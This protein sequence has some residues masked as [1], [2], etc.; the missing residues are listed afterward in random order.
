MNLSNCRN[1]FGKKLNFLFSLGELSFTGKFPKTNKENIP[2]KEISLV[3]CQKCHLVQLNK[4][5]NLNYLYNTDYG[6]RSGINHT[7]R[8][9]LKKVVENLIKI[10]EPKNNDYVLDIASNDGTLLNFYNKKLTTIGVDP[11][12]K[13]F[14]KFYR[15]IN[16]RI[17]GFFSKK[18]LEKILCNNKKIKIISALS[19][20][21]D[22]KK[23]ND[24]LKDI[25]CI[26]DEKVGVFYL[27]FC[28]LGSIIK[29]NLFDTI[30]HEHLE[31]YSIE[32]IIDMA[33]KNQLRVFDIVQNNI[34][35]GSTGF[36]IC[37]KNALY[38]NN[39]TNINKILK[40]EIKLNLKKLKTYKNLFNNILKI[41]KKLTTML[42][43][44]T[45]KGKIIHGY[46]ASTKGNVLIQFFDLNKN[47]IRF[48]S[49]RNPEKKN[50][51]TPGSKIK[52]I[53]EKLSRRLKPD[54]YLVLPWHFKKEILLREK[55]MLKFGTRFIFP[56]PKIK[57][58]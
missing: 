16:Y 54:Y 21:Y 19:V 22:L 38:K 29:K 36:Y 17:N 44:L 53:S 23:P 25:S 8:N 18:V 6:Y 14:S 50:C 3:K 40:T 24:F 20:F 47:Q 35:G 10:V 45:Q 42:E 30:C 5:F 1:C 49:D 55:K 46:G 43:N 32:V 31:Y 39:T 56:L 33:K 11:I 13:K 4:N 28:D 57:I 26:L 2:R 27:E 7:M 34:N 58:I 51:Y 41:K 48:I 12:L 52:I 9:H 15:N 37:K